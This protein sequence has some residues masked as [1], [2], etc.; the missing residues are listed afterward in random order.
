MRTRATFILVSALLFSWTQS[1]LALLQG[2]AGPDSESPWQLLFDGA[3]TTAWRGFKEKEFPTRG[4]TVED[5]C[6]KHRQDGGGGDIVTTETY[7][8]FEFECEWRVGPQANSGI[9][10]LI[11]QERNDPIGHEYQILDDATALKNAPPDKHSTASL[12]DLLAPTN[13][14][15]RAGD[16]FN[17]SRIVVFG[18]RVEHWLNGAKVLEY[19]LGSKPLLAAVAA[20]KF[21]NVSGFGSKI[22]GHILLQD[23]G[24]EVW[25]RHLRI[26]RLT[27]VGLSQ[28]ETDAGWRLLFDGRYPTAWRGLKQ[29]GFP[30]KGWNIEAGCLHVA[31]QGGGGDVV[32]V[33]MFTNFEFAWE[34]RISFDGN[35]GVK[36]L[37]Q[38]AHGPVG[39]EYQ[40]LDDAHNVEGKK[41]SKWA[42]ASLYDVL[43]ATNTVVKPLSE[44]NQSRILIRG[45]H[46][47]HWLNGKMVLAC[48]LESDALKAGIASSKFK[49][50]S[51]YGIKAPG[52]ILLQDHGR[53]VWFR[54]LKIRALPAP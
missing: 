19:E 42:T 3:T 26:R 25:F 5:G 47:E 12:Y 34:W 24:G 48:E 36:Y 7:T 31:P 35:S 23:H 21:K 52:R 6:L 29:T 13:L 43:G 33:A 49:G 11:T 18:R 39:P 28:A 54:N 15:L 27:P 1:E 45:K 51:F 16:Q 4:W 41:G 9:K 37:I 20:S 22:A 2:R 38:D 30:T 10:Y 50:S 53:E 46:V 44:F 17:Q 14:V 32:S 40:M 8:D